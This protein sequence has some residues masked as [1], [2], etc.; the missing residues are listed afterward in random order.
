MAGVM[1]RLPST[2]SLMAR[3]GTP[4][5]RAMAFWEIPMGIRCSSRRISPGV[6][7]GFMSGA[8]RIGIGL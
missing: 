7:G 3:G 1:E 8:E 4:M 6:R 5:A 2:I